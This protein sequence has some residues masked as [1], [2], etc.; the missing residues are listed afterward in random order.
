[1]FRPCWSFCYINYFVFALV[2]LV[3]YPFILFGLWFHLLLFLLFFGV[4]SQFWFVNNFEVIIVFWFFWLYNLLIFYV[5]L[6]L[7]FYFR[8]LDLSC[9]MATSINSPN[10]NRTPSMCVLNIIDGQQK[11]TTYVLK[12]TYW[13]DSNPMML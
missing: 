12:S 8:F 6:R 1:M 4:T 2:F 3:V 13:V 9:S 7:T 5:V 11:M 10:M